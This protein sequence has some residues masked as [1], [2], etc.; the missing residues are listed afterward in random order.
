MIN[1]VRHV[2]LQL[3]DLRMDAFFYQEFNK[4]VEVCEF[5]ELENAVIPLRGKPPKRFTGIGEA[6]VAE[7]V[8]LY[9]RSQF[10]CAIDNLFMQLTKKFH[11]RGL[12]TYQA[13][14]DVLLK[15]EITKEART[16]LLKYPF[17]PES[18]NIEL[19]HLH[20]KIFSP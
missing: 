20:K 17:K 8:Q 3:Q 9:F 11:S 13:L 19:R 16:L 5:L 6:Q 2:M 7:S 1:L 18:L 10:Y 15:G 12:Q 14:K 4:C